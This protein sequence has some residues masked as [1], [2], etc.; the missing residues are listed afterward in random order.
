MAGLFGDSGPATNAY[1]SN[2]TFVAFD[3][4]LNLLYIADTGN[5]RVRVRNCDKIFTI[6]F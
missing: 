2:P 5:H 4:S 6:F 3:A 1:L